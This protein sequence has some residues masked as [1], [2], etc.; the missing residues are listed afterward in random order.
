ME[1]VRPFA[2]P[3]PAGLMVLAFYLVALWPILTNNA[4]HDLATVLIALGFAGGLVQFS[5]GI[6]ELRNGEI[7]SGNIMLAFSTFMWLG[8]FEFLGKALHII[9]PNTAPIDG[10]V[11]LVMGVLMSGF[12][13]A[14]LKTNKVAFYFMFFTDIFFISGGLFF[15]TLIKPFIFIMGWVLPI[16]IILIVWLVL[17]TVLNTALNKTFIPL[18][19]PY[20]KQDENK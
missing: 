9:P 7:L 16:I 18:G 4:P 3:G 11:F 12:T 13:I 10:W 14:Y 15:L 19:E 8:F 1:N 17:G 20:W 2:N 6:I 5:C